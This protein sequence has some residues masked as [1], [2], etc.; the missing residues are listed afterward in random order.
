MEK[1]LE[2]D[3]YKVRYRYNV[4]VDNVPT[5]I[6]YTAKPIWNC[7]G[8]PSILLEFMDKTFRAYY[9]WVVRNAVTLGLPTGTTYDYIRERVGYSGSTPIEIHVGY[10]PELHGTTPASLFQ[11][12]TSQDTSKPTL[13]LDYTSLRGVDGNFQLYVE[14]YNSDPSSQDSGRGVNVWNYKPEQYIYFKSDREKNNQTYFGLELEVNSRLPWHEL[15]RVMTEVQPKQEPFMYAKSD[16]SIGGIHNNCYEIVTHPMTPKRMRKE[17]KVFFGKLNTLMESRG[18]TTDQLFDMNSATNGIHIHI[19]RTAFESTR[20]TDTRLR[21]RRTC[22]NRIGKF[23]ALFNRPEQTYV[24][25]IEG[26]AKR[27]IT[28]NQYC[29]ASSYFEGRRTSYLVRNHDA[30][31]ERYQACN[32]N[33]SQTVEVRVFKGTP[34]LDHILYCIDTVEA[35]LDFSFNM[36]YSKLNTRIKSSF[37][38][39]LANQPNYKYKTMRKELLCA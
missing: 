12:S 15:E 6:D 5:V 19:S 33:N 4:M 25:F 2:F 39:W 27:D 37:S 29:R 9:N 31:H 1:I 35:L 34:T 38:K 11:E 3:E 32:L 13:E 16:S 23:A 8:N 14:L 17:F 30:T 28:H 36:P 18:Y 10:M 7:H 20:H 21:M 26:L 22:R 24:S